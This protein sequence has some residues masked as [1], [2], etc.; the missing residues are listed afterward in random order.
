MEHRP[1]PPNATQPPQSRFPWPLIALII[2]GALLVVTLWLSTSMNKAS[3]RE[4]NMA[5]Q[6]GQLRLS[7]VSLAPQEANNQANVDVYGEVS[8]AG[9]QPV[10]SAII[11]AVFKDKNGDPIVTQQKPMERVDVEKKDKTLAPENFLQE[12]LQ[13]GRSSGFRV[14]YT[15]IPQNWN[16][17]PP[18]L[19][20]LQVTI[21]K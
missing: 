17:E 8:N 5:S 20:V 4:L 6:T 11:S 1:F 3:T 21:K 2:A 15:E 13:P 18:Q 14:S 10:T 7:S 19:S 9:G 12:P 16:H